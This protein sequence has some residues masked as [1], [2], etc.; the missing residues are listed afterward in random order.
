MFYPSCINYFI[1]Q[2]YILIASFFM[3]CVMNI[4]YNITSL[5]K[6]PSKTPIEILP[7]GRVAMSRAHFCNFSRLPTRHLAP[8]SPVSG[9]GSHGFEFSSDLIIFGWILMCLSQI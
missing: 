5:N 6:K 3:H 9:S 1:S 4:L 8:N 2:L 7:S